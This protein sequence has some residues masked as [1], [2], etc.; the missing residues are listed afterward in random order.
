MGTQVAPPPSNDD[1]DLVAFWNFDFDAAPRFAIEDVTGHGN[2][3]LMSAAPTFE[4][5]R[6]MAVCGNG[7]VEGEE[8]CDT[9]SPAA[10]SGCSPDCRVRFLAP[11]PHSLLPLSLEEKIF[12]ALVQP[13]AS[14]LR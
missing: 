10:G 1:P 11:L 9:G 2:D 12:V 6:W 7:V 5:I 3:L 8:E 13:V 14:L 4:V